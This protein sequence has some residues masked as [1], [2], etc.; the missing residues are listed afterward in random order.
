MFSQEEIEK[1]AQRKGDIRGVV[2]QTVADYVL[3][4]WGA[5]GLDRVEKKLKEWGM[6]FRYE[7]VRTLDWYP[8]GWGALSVLAVAEAFS[9]DE[10]GV[11]NMG[12]SVPK[13]SLV[14]KL[15]FKF[16][17]DIEKFARQLPGYWAKHYTIGSVEVAKI[18]KKN[19]EI[20]LYLKGAAFHPL[21]CKY[22]EGYI[23]KAVELARPTGS[24]IAA[25]ELQCTFKDNTPY[26]VYQ[27][28]WTK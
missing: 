22:I 15:L 13:I 6:P 14:V 10:L 17:L 3:K 19:K 28:K 18:D 8:V 20:I 4:K 5:E 11:K 26:E 1:I 27:I 7:E 24:V 23:E 16:F 21:L 12:S 2:F 25:K 9:L